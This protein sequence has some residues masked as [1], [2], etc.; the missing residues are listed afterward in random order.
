MNY[1]IEIYK[2]HPSVTCLNISEISEVLNDL[3][4]V[5]FSLQK[6]IEICELEGEI[7]VVSGHEY[8]YLYWINDIKEIKIE[9][10]KPTNDTVLGYHRCQAQEIH[11]ISDLNNYLVD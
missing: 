7:V 6:P 1:E 3:L 9:W 2:L 5:E 8:C 4:R 11:L 10:V